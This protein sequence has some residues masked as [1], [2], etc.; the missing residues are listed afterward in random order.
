MA[1]LTGKKIQDTYDGVIKL[2]DN[3]SLT[4]SPKKITD[5]LGNQTP[6]S[7]SDTEVI[8]TSD[9]EATGF[10][11]ATGTKAQVL[12]ADGSVQ[13]RTYTH[14]QATSSTTWSI[15]HN[16]D[17]FPSVTV[18]DSVGNICVGH[19]SYVDARNITLTFNQAFKGRAYLN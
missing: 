5:G 9:I 1:T 3:G 4:S 13:E 17:T 19:I 16:L 10:K 15:N 18:I 2:D 11:T 12:A 7:V 8:S 6:L 14:V